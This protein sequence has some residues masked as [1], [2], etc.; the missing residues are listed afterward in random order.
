MNRFSRIFLLIVALGSVLATN[1]WPTI[2]IAQQT[3]TTINIAG[4][5][6]RVTVQVRADRND[7]AVAWASTARTVQVVQIGTGQRLGDHMA[8]S[9]MAALRSR[10]VLSGSKAS[11]PL[12]LNAAGST[13]SSPK[14]VASAS[15]VASRGALS[16]GKPKGVPPRWWAPLA[17]CA[18]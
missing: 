18:P 2:T 6:D 11:T 17:G 14:S 9:L 7:R 8:R 3:P 4:L 13:P 1:R 5:H 12:G 10:L 15:A 16:A